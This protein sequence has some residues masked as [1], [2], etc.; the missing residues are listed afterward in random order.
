[1]IRRPPR[2]TLFPYTTLFRSLGQEVIEDG[3]DR[4][5]QLAGVPR[6]ADQDRALREVDDDERTGLGAV[7]RRVGVHLGGLQHGP[8]WSEGRESGSGATAED[9]GQEMGAS[10]VRIDATDAESGN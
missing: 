9:I 3:E 1:M 10:T 6:A 8:V 4:F 2:S 5:L 7:Q